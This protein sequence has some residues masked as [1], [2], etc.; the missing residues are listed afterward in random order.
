MIYDVAD[1]A[2]KAMNRANLKAFGQLKLAKWDELKVVKLVGKTYDDSANEARRWYKQIGIEAYERA[3]IE[4]G[5]SRKDAS[6]TARKKIT[7]DWIL[8]MLEESDPVTLYV[9]L[10]ETDRKKQR[11]IEALAATDNKP[12]EI[13]KALRYWTMQVGQYADNTVSRARIEAFR[14]AGVREVVFHTQEDD[15]VCNDC[16]P[17]DGQ[18]FPI[19]EA[20][21]PPLHRNCRCWLGPALD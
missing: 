4:C 21:Q 8:D 11:L 12:A 18:T 20:P 6:V 3:L 10:T 19:D 17:L 1:K 16:N 14:D 2:I 7:G 5:R 13:D 15:R 9:F